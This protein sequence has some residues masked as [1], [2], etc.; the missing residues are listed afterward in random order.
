MEE[1]MHIPCW[2]WRVDALGGM[3]LIISATFILI[4]SFLIRSEQIWQNE[5]CLNLKGKHDLGLLRQL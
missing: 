3:L 2:Y 5:N 1:K 4:D